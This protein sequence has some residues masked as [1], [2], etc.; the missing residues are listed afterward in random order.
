[1]RNRFFSGLLTAAL[2][3]PDLVL[4]T[5]DLGFGAVDDFAAARPGQFVNAGVAEQNMAGLAAGIALAGGRVF[6]YSI[7]NFPTL[8]C[9][10]QI[11]NDI[12]YH[13]ADVT[14]VAVGG[15]LAYGALGMSHHATEDLAIMRALPGMAVAAPGDPAE[16]DA[17]LSDLLAGGGPAYLRLG[18]TGERMLHT[19]GVSAPRGTSIPLGGT[20]GEVLLCSTGAILDATCDAAQLLRAKGIRADVRSFPWLDPFDAVAVRQAAGEYEALITVEEHSIV[21][22]LGS[23]VAEVLA[24]SAGGTPLIRIALPPTSSSVVGDQQY[25]RAAF[26][27]DAESISRRVRNHLEANRGL[28]SQIR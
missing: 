10:E 2:V 18:K 20:G 4:I 13:H 28:A 17:V 21:G 23:A 12:C 5:A 16:V 19:G 26:E 22:G 3:D 25:L 9:L 1:M 14:V 8:R 7:A 27:L 24:E 15:G 6:T 11:R